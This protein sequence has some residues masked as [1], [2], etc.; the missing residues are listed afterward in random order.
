MKTMLMR[1]A[2]TTM[3]MLV[4]FPA[5]AAKW[6]HVHILVTDTKMA[7]AWYAEHFGGQVTKSGPFD[8]VLFGPDL[9]KFRKNTPET[10]GSKDSSIGQIGFTYSDVKLKLKALKYSGVKVVSEVETIESTDFGTLH[11]AY[12][13]DPW[14]TRIGL[15]NDDTVKGFHHVHVYAAETAIAWYAKNFGDEITAFKGIP[16]LHGIRYGDMWLLIEQGDSPEPSTGHSI[17]HMGWNFER[18]DEA[19]ASFR[20]QK[21]EFALEPRPEEHPT[22]AYIVGPD[23]AKTEIVRSGAH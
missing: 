15:V 3:A 23:S 20:E 8:A 11:Y 4:A 18:F 2:I 19:V 13:E 12:V 7:A 16:S 5:M 21:T 10:K 22:M 17:D 14:G 9:V 1:C 6:D